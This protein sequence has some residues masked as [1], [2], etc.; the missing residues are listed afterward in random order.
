MIGAHSWPAAGSN[1]TTLVVKGVEVLPTGPTL[2][3][4]CLSSPADWA[5]RPGV[6]VPLRTATFVWPGG[7]GPLPVS[8][9]GVAV[10]ESPPVILLTPKT[11]PASRSRAPTVITAIESGLESQA[12]RL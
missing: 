2:Y 10:S 5:A 7:H 6:A 4:L 11:A 8:S 12:G 9:V 1:M 3:W